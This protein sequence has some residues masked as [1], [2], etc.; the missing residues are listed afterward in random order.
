MHNSMACERQVKFTPKLYYEKFQIYI[1]VERNMG[2]PWWLSN[3]ESFCQCKRHRFGP[4]GQEAPLNKEPRWDSYLG[5]PMDR[6]AWQVAVQ[7]VTESDMT[8]GLN[9]K[10][11][12]YS[13]QPN[14]P[15]QK[16]YS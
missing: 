2:L 4:R 1:K 7:G 15:P 3:K 16:L 10:K 11:E 5:N 6:G 14:Y 12:I 9:K 13:E 8:E